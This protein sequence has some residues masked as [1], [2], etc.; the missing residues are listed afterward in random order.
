MCWPW[1]NPAQKFLIIGSGIFGLVA[2][3]AFL[4]GTESL[5]GFTGWSGVPLWLEY[6]LILDWSRLAPWHWANLV[7]AV[8]GIAMLWLAG[9]AVAAYKAGMD[10]GTET[11]WSLPTMHGLW[12][13]RTLAVIATLVLALGSVVVHLAP[14]WLDYLPARQAQAV[15]GFY[16]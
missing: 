13:L 6:M 1:T 7:I 15:I 4:I 3:F 5:L 11:P 10:Y 16:G 9:N 8:T 14:G 12:R 2:V